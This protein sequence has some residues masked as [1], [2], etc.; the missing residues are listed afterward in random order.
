MFHFPSHKILGSSSNPLT[1]PLPSP[2][3]LKFLPINGGDC[4]VGLRPP[5][6]D[7]QTKRATLASPLHIQ[8]TV[9]CPLPATSSSVPYTKGQ[10]RR[11]LCKA[12]YRACASECA[13]PYFPTC[14]RWLPRWA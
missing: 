9:H 5:R 13:G 7:G 10:L 4:H 1:P 2:Q 11:I 8:S 14:R 3:A 6:N 12:A